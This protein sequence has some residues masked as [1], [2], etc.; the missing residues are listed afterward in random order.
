MKSISAD[1]IQAYLKSKS[2]NGRIDKRGGLSN[3]SLSDI[4]VIV[5]ET[6]KFGNV[7]DTSIDNLRASTSQK[8]KSMRVLNERE[9]TGLTV[10]LLNNTDIYIKWEF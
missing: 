7:Y 3:K 5:K 4:L 1:R 2:E 10:T 6:L 9:Q 8:H